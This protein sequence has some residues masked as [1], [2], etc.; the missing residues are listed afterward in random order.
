MN[1]LS[2]NLGFDQIN[3]MRPIIN[4][5]HLLRASVDGQFNCMQLGINNQVLHMGLQNLGIKYQMLKVFSL[6]QYL[7]LTL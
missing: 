4:F 7:M 3:V 2:S 5:K 6:H 1:I